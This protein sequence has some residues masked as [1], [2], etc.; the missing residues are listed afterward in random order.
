MLCYLA[1]PLHIDCLARG[2]HALYIYETELLQWIF[3]VPIMKIILS[4]IIVLL[5][6]CRN[7]LNFVIFVISLKQANLSSMFDLHFSAN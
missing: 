3:F 4:L 1:I 5:C 7:Y 2:L 6:H